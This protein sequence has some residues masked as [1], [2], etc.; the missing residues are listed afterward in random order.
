MHPT[1]YLQV[2]MAHC[3]CFSKTQFGK[4]IQYAF[5]DIKY[6]FPMDLSE[7]VSEIEQT[8]TDVIVVMDLI[9]KGTRLT[10]PKFNRI[11]NTCFLAQ[12][13]QIKV[14]SQFRSRLEVELQKYF[15]DASDTLCLLSNICEF[16]NLNPTEVDAAHHSIASI[17]ATIVSET[18]FRPIFDT[19]ATKFEMIK[20][21]A[22]SVELTLSDRKAQLDSTNDRMT[23]LRYQNHTCPLCRY[24]PATYVALP[25]M[26]P[27]FCANCMKDLTEAKSVF[28]NCFHCNEKVKEVKGLSY[29]R[30]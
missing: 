30:M 12:F 28:S 17:C 27:C 13:K 21:I 9:D 16:C 7:M 5:P 4:M 2:Q 23:E 26:H 1:N 14:E 15:T 24:Q 22:E 10:S 18:P 8:S 29:L 6:Y 3:A 19:K 11:L 25:C 20:L